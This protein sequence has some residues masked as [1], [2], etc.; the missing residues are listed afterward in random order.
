M[1]I[2]TEK[3]FIRLSFPFDKELVRLCKLA[4]GVWSKTKRDWRFADNYMNRL[5]L[6]RAFP[7]L[8]PCVKDNSV[9]ELTIPSFLMD[10]QKSALRA[11]VKNDRRGFFHDTGLGKTIT[12]IEIYRHHQA[13]TLVVCPLS[14]ID[15]AWFEEI[16]NRYPD[17]NAGNLWIAKKKGAAALNE[18]LKKELCVINYES[19]RTIDKQLA[20]AGFEMVILDESARIRSPKS[21]T[22][23]KIIEFCDNVQ[24]VYELSGVP[25]PNSLLEY[26]T[27]IRILDPMLWGKSFYK[28]RTK[29]FYP[30]GYGGYTWEVKPEFKDKIMED[31]KSVAEYVNKEDVLDLPERTESL[32]IF[33]L[34]PTERKHY[35]D[36][37]RELITILESGEAITAPNAVTAIM[38]LRQVSSG[39]LLDEDKFYDLGDSK[40]TELL[41][42]IE[43][44]GKKQV[45]IWTN[46]QHEARVI[47]DALTERGLSSDILNG[48]ISEK[49][50]QATLSEFKEGKLQYIICHP[51]SVGFGHTL[52]NCSEAIYYSSSYSYEDLYQSKDRIYRYGQKNKCSYYFLIADKTIDSVI[53]KAIQKKGST[54]QAILDYLKK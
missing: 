39:F 38:K 2:K 32:R 40:L 28:F 44:I 25:A 16:R 52:T 15:G 37:R 31:I 49:Q 45:I 42:L 30:F 7:G 29:F 48:T 26:W 35:N 36:I 41:T 23:K 51:K 9:K 3:S 20:G 8:I 10:H 12:T 34:S 1:E 54:G 24:Y 22:A 4:G 53:L 11:S 19:F 46:F 17:I 14:L 43:D 33:Q 47:W 18:S 27:Q 6:N 13:K 5:C 50:K 21:I